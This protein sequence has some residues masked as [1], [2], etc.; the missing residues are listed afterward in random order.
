MNTPSQRNCRNFYFWTLI[1]WVIYIGKDYFIY[2]GDNGGELG[3]MASLSQ[4][5]TDLYGACCIGNYAR[6]GSEITNHILIFI[7]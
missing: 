6:F 2:V 4:C 5:K 1:L 3:H 7:R